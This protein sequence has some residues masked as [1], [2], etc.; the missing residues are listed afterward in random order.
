MIP[1]ARIMN[2]SVDASSRDDCLLMNDL[3]NHHESKTWHIETIVPDVV[4]P[5]VEK[6]VMLVY[7]LLLEF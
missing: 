1:V 2:N 6:K 3:A 7:L 5:F 4:R